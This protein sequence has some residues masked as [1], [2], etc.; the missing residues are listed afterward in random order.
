MHVKD[1]EGNL[2]DLKSAEVTMT[3]G[4]MLLMIYH[5]MAIIVLVNML[6]AMM[7]NSFQTI[8]NQA[9]IEW[10]FARS[11]LWLGYFDEGS[12]LPPPLNTIVSPKSIWRFGR[13]LVRL[14]ICSSKSRNGDHS[15]KSSRYRKRKSTVKPYSSPSRKHHSMSNRVNASTS[16]RAGSVMWS[17]HG[18]E[19]AIRLPRSVNNGDTKEKPAIITIQPEEVIYSCKQIMGN[20]P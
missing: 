4:E 3:V 6:I 7:S 15:K 9:D 19:P 20:N 17:D 12:T 5:A 13:A 11:K 2:V 8:Q 14:L 16:G 18:G 10:K 1:A